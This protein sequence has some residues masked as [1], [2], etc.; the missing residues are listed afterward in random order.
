MKILLT[1]A[2]GFLGKNLTPQLLKRKYKIL[3]LT[4]KSKVIKKNLNQQ[5]ITSSIEHIN[6][7]NLIKIKKFKP[8]ILINLAWEGIPDFS[9]KKSIKNLNSQMAFIQKISDVKSLKKIINIGSCWEYNNNI[10]KCTE[11]QK[12]F[13]TKYFTWSKYALLNFIKLKCKEKNIN[14]IWFRVFYMY[15]EHQKQE[16]L[17]PTIFKSLSAFKKPILFSP[18]VTN[19]YIHVDD[20]CRAII[21]G[22]NKKS[23][24][25]IFN[26]GS[27]Q[28]TSV[29]SIYNK[30]LKSM[31]LEN[32]SKFKIKSKKY[33]SKS[34]F[35][36][37][38][39]IKNELNWEPQVS[40]DKAIENLNE[41]RK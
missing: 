9:F 4:K 2:S 36:C 6:K 17:I 26:V 28:L 22:I 23:A 33:K 16:S 5:I 32:V 15:G 13:P 12:I 20:V 3:I 10:G 19:D 31:N 7:K 27:A 24:N 30:I 11:N 25:G 18:S 1:G 29:L 39:K 21:K 14:Y 8:D 34:N 41:L 37:L 40:M 38:K 35:A